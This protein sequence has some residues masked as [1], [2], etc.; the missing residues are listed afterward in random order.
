[1]ASTAPS[2]SPESRVAAK[3]RR[4]VGMAV[5]VSHWDDC[6]RLVDAV[7]DA[8]GTCDV[9]VNNTGLSPLYPDLVSVTEA[10]YDVDL[11][12]RNRSG[13]ASASWSDNIV[14]GSIRWTEVIA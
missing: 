5:N 11:R 9:L 10:L 4:A 2:S 12:F 13:L 1:M 7:Y 14:D 3:N 8:F 6:D